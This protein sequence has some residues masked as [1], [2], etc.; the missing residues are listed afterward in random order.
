MSGNSTV[1][2]TTAA[3]S[4]ALFERASAVIPG[5]VNSPVRAFH[6]VGGTPRFMVSGQGP[7]LTD[8]DGNQSVKVFNVTGAVLEFAGVSKAYGGLRPLRIAELRV[9]AGDRVAILGLDQ[10]TAEVF[11][12]LATGATLPDAGAVS[13]FGRDT[14][15]MAWQFSA[16]IW[17]PMGPSPCTL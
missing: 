6:S 17:P 9:A 13:V 3:R 7:Y 11:V 16:R 12:N 1:T 15:A 5:G 4:A 8:A 14:K 10:P 2:D